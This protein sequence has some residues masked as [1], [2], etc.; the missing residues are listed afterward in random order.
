[1]N[2]VENTEAVETDEPTPPH[3]TLLEVWR[4]LLRP[5][6]ENSVQPISLQWAVR[7][8]QEYPHLTFAELDKVRVGYFARLDELVQ[9]LHYEIESDPDALTR[10][11]LEDDQQ[12][13]AHH[14]KNL[15]MLWQEAFILWESEWSATSK[16]AAIDAAV[17]A[18]VH[19]MILGPNSLVGHLDSISFEFTEADQQ[20]LADA[21]SEFDRHLKGGNGE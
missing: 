19:K 12:Y 5:A 14:Y 9:I 6:R 7:L 16:T 11:V 13:N 20:V 10:D 18:E 1:M 3:R 4:E 2:L 21:L 17:I 15:L 8:K